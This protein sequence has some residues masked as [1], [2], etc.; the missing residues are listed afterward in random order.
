MSWIPLLK[1]FIKWITHTKCII[2]TFL[3]N[4]CLFTH[5]LLPFRIVLLLIIYIIKERR[6]LEDNILVGIIVALLAF[7]FFFII[8]AIV[9]YV[10]S[11]IGLFKI[12]KKEG[13]DEIA[14]LAWIPIVNQFLMTWL[15]EDD[16]HPSLRG[17]VT[18]I[19]GISVA[20]SLLLS[21]FVYFV[22]FIPM[23]I[24]FYA[25]YFIANKY[26]SNPILHVV[27]AIITLGLSIPI[28][29]FIFRK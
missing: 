5:S 25:F 3:F 4:K 14:W 21:S 16:V 12:A 23:V 2:E 19:Y 22:T 1:R 7:S 18:L 28:Q 15:V 6:F 9:L 17:K 11:A 29:L 8:L 26:S 10:L 27:I 24:F 20:V 13:K